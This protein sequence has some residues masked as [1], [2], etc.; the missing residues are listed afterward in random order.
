MGE[1]TNDMTKRILIY[2]PVLAGKE[3]FILRVKKLSK[4][5]SSVSMRFAGNQV[6]QTK[7]TN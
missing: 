7:N 5:P 6:E 1:I 2:S 3:K 4:R